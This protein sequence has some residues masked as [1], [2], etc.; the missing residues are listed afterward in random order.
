MSSDKQGL[1]REIDRRTIFRATAWAAPVIAVAT[2]APHAAASTTTRTKEAAANKYAPSIGSPN[3][4]QIQINTVQIWYDWN[5]WGLNWDSVPG[6][7]D[8]TWEVYLE[9]ENGNRLQTIYTKSGSLARS[10]N[11]QYSGFV[12]GLTSGKT[13][14]VVSKITSATFNPVQVGTNKFFAIVPS[15]SSTSV[16]VK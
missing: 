12:N 8:V 1:N 14:T 10:G 7:V 2:V 15:S 6:S 3:K 13:Y 11:F 4:G 16:T 9:D 5:A